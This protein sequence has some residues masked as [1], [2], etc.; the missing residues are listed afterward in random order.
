MKKEICV[1][2]KTIT[3]YGGDEQGL[4]VVVYN[5]FEGDGS[6]VW[7]ACEKSRCRGFVL[8]VIS[9]VSWNSD[10]TPWA[11]EDSDFT[12][13]ADQYLEL[14]SDKLLPKIA[15][16]LGYNPTYYAL[17]GYSLGGLFALYAAYR[18]S[19]FSRIV[20]ASGSLW[21]PGFAEFATGHTP[22]NVAK[23][24]LSLGNKEKNTKNEKMK[25]VE[26]NTVKLYEYY[27][28]IGIETHFELNEGGHFKD[29]DVRIAKGIQW[30]LG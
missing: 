17:A 27:Q 4:P 25:S 22:G 5:T 30:M 14:L 29:C 20:S 7:M 24:Y 3:L 23:I 19:A 6:E 1:E 28:N 11:A 21:Y 13:G 18:T 2:D 26:D 10:M 15:D 16:A 9:N 8:A 12:G